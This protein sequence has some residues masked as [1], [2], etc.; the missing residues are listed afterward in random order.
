MSTERGTEMAT[1]TKRRLYQT[2]KIVG[3][4][5]DPYVQQRTIVATNIMKVAYVNCGLAE[6]SWV[7]VDDKPL[8]MIEWGGFS[9]EELFKKLT[10]VDHLKAERFIHMNYEP[11]PMSDYFGGP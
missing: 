6:K 10:G 3:S 2:N 9:P 4:R 8:D 7:E 1:I 5:H 11:D